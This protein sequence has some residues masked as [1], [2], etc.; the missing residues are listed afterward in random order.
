MILAQAALALLAATPALAAERNYAVAGFDR[1]S[2]AG[3]F[4]VD[5]KVGGPVSVH[6]TGAQTAIDHL[7]VRVDGD[8]L[9]IEQVKGGWGGWPSREM[10]KLAVSVTVPSLR[11][12][13][14]AGSGNVRV[15]RARTPT[16]DLS[17]AGSGN[18]AIGMVQADI[19]AMKVAG[20][21]DLAISGRAARAKASVAGSGNVRAAGLKV[22]DA[23][24]AVVGSGDLALTASRSATGSVAGSGN[25]VITG[26]ARC[27]VAKRGSGDVDCRGR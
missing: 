17:V 3:P 9:R 16:L 25:I 2:A 1:L 26:G 23:T 6:V 8:L 22:L 7:V 27:T 24:V 5:V 15:D 14:L 11:A 13:A 20:S 18:L 10:G 19:V 12:V 21:G 4:D